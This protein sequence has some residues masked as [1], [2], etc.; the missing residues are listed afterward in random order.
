MEH[1]RD[2]DGLRGVAV[3]A[4]VLFHARFPGFQG[5]FVGVDVFFVISGYLITSIIRKEIQGAR[6]TLANFYERR[7]RRILPALLVTILATW[8]A[9]FWLYMPPDF[10][11]YSTSVAATAVFGSNILF[12]RQGGYFAGPAEIKPLLNLWSLAVEE[13]F[14]LLFPLVML[15][16]SRF[17]PAIRFV[18]IGV[19]LLMSLG[20]SVLETSQAPAAAFYLAPTRAWEL[21]AGALL[22]LDYLPRIAGRLASEGEAVI[23]LGMILWAVFAFSSETPFP[24]ASAT[25][26]S[27][28]TALLIHA[29][30]GSVTVV[31]RLLGS[32]PLVYMG[33]ISYSFYLLHWPF[34]AVVR[35]YWIAPLPNYAA[36]I[37]VI[38]AG[39]AAV[40]SWKYVE[41][42]MRTG[43]SR[44]TRRRLFAGAAIASGLLVAA[45]LAG[46]LNHG[47]P[48]RY[49]GYSH[50]EYRNHLVEYN[51]ETCFLMWGQ[52][53]SDWKGD[54][55]F[56]SRQGRPT[57]LLWGDS[58]SA[59]LA[60]GIKAASSAIKYDILQYS[61]AS[62][63]PI[64]G[65][66]SAWRG[67]CRLAADEA[68]AIVRRYSIAKVILAAN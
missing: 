49:T 3:S 53:I 55:C 66:E 56:L 52:P 31:R 6:F 37:V 17:R 64:V 21:M 13:Q 35:Y 38:L 47:F 65:H 33:L 2:I 44:I 4:V 67:D 57:A 30:A 8:I 27:V 68:L 25:L 23:G 22:A 15:L 7:V 10:E 29:G 45:G 26:P 41:Q 5:G 32:K 54:Q 59:H 18:T 50:M 51:E 34:L 60:P 14:Y 11:S 62:C 28:G 12:W 61:V 43:R 20:A 1:R 42:P 46:R 63:A 36:M 19:I 40:L 48:S 16:L 9:A 58:F 24:G 39:V